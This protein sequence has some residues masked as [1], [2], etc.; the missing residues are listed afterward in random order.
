LAPLSSLNSNKGIGF[1]EG[2][3]LQFKVDTGKLDEAAGE[4][5]KR[6][7]AAIVCPGAAVVWAARRETR[8]IP[9]LA[10]QPPLQRINLG[11][12]AKKYGDD[13]DPKASDQ[14]VS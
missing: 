10:H 7:P 3:N 1:V 8:T 11:G 9:I 5:V 2:A 6:A 13:E 14:Q 12:L 4:V